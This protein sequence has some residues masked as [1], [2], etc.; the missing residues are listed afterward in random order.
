M[1][2]WSKKMTPEMGAA[3]VTGASSGIG[4]AT[5]LRLVRRGTRYYMLLRAAGE[6]EDRIVSMTGNT[7][8][9][10]KTIRLSQ[11]TGGAGRTSSVRIRKLEIHAERFE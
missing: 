6:T 8:T 2:V 9:P 10:I 3:W 4:R 1:S 7:A 11:H 5:A